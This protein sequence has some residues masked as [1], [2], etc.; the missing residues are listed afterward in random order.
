MCMIPQRLGRFTT[1]ASRT[2]LL[3]SLS[4]VLRFDWNGIFR[5]CLRVFS[6]LGEWTGSLTGAWGKQDANACRYFLRLDWDDKPHRLGG[7]PQLIWTHLEIPLSGKQTKLKNGAKGAFGVHAGAA[8]RFSFHVY[9]KTA[10]RLPE[11]HWVKFQPLLRMMLVLAMMLLFAHSW[12][13]T[14]VK[15]TWLIST[16]AGLSIDLRRIV[17][18]GSTHLHGSDGGVSYLNAVW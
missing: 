10:T 17:T 18:N 1:S 6:S 11:A 8:I 7:A 9:N 13:N 3:E 12:G 16:C 14:S 4:R 15:D 5:L 2:S